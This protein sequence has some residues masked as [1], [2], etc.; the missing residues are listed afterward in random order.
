[1][2]SIDAGKLAEVKPHVWYTVAQTAE[3]IGR[4]EETTA[5]YLRPRGGRPPK[6]ASV[7]DPLDG[8]RRLV[9]GQTLLALLGQLLIENA[10]APPSETE[11]ERA[12]RGRRAAAEC[13]QL[14]GGRG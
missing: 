8:R 1:M 6:L 14:A 10:P 11:R 7:V 4:S 9:S 13:R 2:K 3:L 5:D 12:A